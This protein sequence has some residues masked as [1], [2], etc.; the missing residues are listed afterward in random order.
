M[1]YFDL[2]LTF[3]LPSCEAARLQSDFSSQTRHRPLRKQFHHM[4]TS[5]HISSL[6]QTSPSKGKPSPAGPSG[7]RACHFP[8]RPHTFN[9]VRLPAGASAVF[10]AFSAASFSSRSLFSSCI[11]LEAKASP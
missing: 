11:T 2:G 10:L 4:I 6:Q 7:T 9:R 8:A 3:T 5:G 1:A